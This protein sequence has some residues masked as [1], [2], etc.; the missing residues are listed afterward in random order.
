MCLCAS[1]GVMVAC[2]VAIISH[3]I[4]TIKS[5]KS[6]FLNIFYGI[7]FAGIFVGVMY[8]A[9]NI[10]PNI[11]PSI[12][13]KIV[14]LESDIN[15]G[16]DNKT[17]TNSNEKIVTRDYE[18]HGDDV[19]NNR[20]TLWSMAINTIPKSPIVGFST[21]S[22]ASFVCHNM[23]LS[24]LLFYGILGFVPFILFLAFSGISGLKKKFAKKLSVQENS[25]LHILLLFWVVVL[26]YSLTA[27]PLI[28]A[29]DTLSVVAWMFMGY[30]ISSLFDTISVE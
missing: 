8:Y 18:E 15:E 20:F 3:Y 7:F 6:A 28:N 4:I 30:I 22:D 11:V 24:S 27:D 23:Y 10:I 25:V 14:N 19:S 29:Y 2:A 13:S 17:V 16:V 21:Y 9:P 1:R 5:I 12:E 26:V